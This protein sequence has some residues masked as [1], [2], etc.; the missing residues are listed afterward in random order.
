M[1]KLLNFG[2]WVG[3]IIIAVGSSLV[4]E[5]ALREDLVRRRHKLFHLTLV[6][7]IV[8]IIGIIRL[9]V[10]LPSDLELS[11]RLED[12]LFL[13]FIRFAKVVVSIV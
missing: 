12:P 13:L 11:F 4:V 8:I 3:H 9:A 7:L 1:T 10:K 2:D 5:L 6:A